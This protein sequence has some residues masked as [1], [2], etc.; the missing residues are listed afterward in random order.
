MDFEGQRR[1]ERLLIQLLVVFAAVGFIVGYAINSFAVMAYINA[2]GFALT[3]LLVVPDWPIFR[4]QP[5]NWL[6]P[7]N[8]TQ[9]QSGATTPA[10]KQAPSKSRK[11]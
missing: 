11:Q 8:P 7:L 4:R 9:P 10:A 2:A 6:P 5:L 1:A 3:S